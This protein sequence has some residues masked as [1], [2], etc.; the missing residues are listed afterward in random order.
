MARRTASER[1]TP[2]SARINASMRSSSIA[3]V[4]RITNVSIYEYN[5]RINAHTPQ[6]PHIAGIHDLVDAD[7][8]RFLVL[9]LVEGETL[10]ERLAGLRAKG[11][12]GQETADH[13]ITVRLTN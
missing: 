1:L 8:V 5:M 6:A 4:V 11:S 12:G 3:M 2:F 9:E 7:G 10:G 13:E